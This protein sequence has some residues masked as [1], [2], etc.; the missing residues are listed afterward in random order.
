VLGPALGLILTSSGSR[1]NCGRGFFSDRR[2]G[3][4]WL[5]G[6]RWVPGSRRLGGGKIY[7]LLL[8]REGPGTDAATAIGSLRVGASRVP[9][10][11]VTA[12]A[13]VPALIQ[14]L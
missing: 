8:L 1:G 2:S 11:A 12:P 4:C 3:P 9:A 7:N 14:E 13:P 6:W 5:W 10:T